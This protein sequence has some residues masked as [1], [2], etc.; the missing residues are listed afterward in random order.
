[1]SHQISD[2][3]IELVHHFKAAFDDAVAAGIG[4]ARYQRGRKD[5]IG[6]A[7]QLVDVFLRSEEEGQ[8]VASRR[9]EE[10][11]APWSSRSQRAALARTLATRA[12]IRVGSAR[13]DT[14]LPTKPLRTS[15]A[16]TG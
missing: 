5:G 7:L 3:R 14:S 6:Q 1:M 11:I 12:A 4:E 8:P 2:I 15:S 9:I 16:A 13:N 10:I